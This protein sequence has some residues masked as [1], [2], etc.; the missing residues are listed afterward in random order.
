M[1]PAIG[2]CNLGGTAESRV[3]FE[4]MTLTK[5]DIA[6]IFSDKKSKKFLSHIKFVD[7]D[8]MKGELILIDDGVVAVC[9]QRQENKV[10]VL[11]KIIGKEEDFLMAY[12]VEDSSYRIYLESSCS[13]ISVSKFCR[14]SACWAVPVYI[15][16]PSL[17]PELCDR[18]VCKK[19]T[20]T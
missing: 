9:R 17:Y 13:E 5:E 7:F 3:V 1:E 10:F 6:E 18:E 19:F 11:V 16:F 14:N 8:K 12:E 20:N 15:L 2:I 4:P